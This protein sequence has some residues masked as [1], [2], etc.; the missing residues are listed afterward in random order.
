MEISLCMIVKDEEEVIERCIKSVIEVV[1]EIIIVDTGSV[2]STISIAEK[3]GAKVYN[4]EW[5]NDFSKARNYSFSKATKDYIL[6][7]DADDVLEESSLEEFKKIKNELNENIDS[8][9]MNYIINV[10][11]ENIPI[12]TIRR[13]RLVKKVN[14]FKWKGMVHEYLEVEGKIYI[15]NINIYH[16]K[17]KETT[18]RNLKIYENMIENGEELSARDMYHYGCELYKNN[19]YDESI[20]QFETYIDSKDEWI[21]AI[22]KTLNNLIEIYIAKGDIEN[23]IKYILKLSDYDIP[24]AEFCCKL[25]Y[26]YLQ[27]QQINESIYWY[28]M[29]LNAKC[30]EY[31]ARLDDYDSK[32]FTPWFYLGVC[33]IIKGD[34]KNAHKCNERAYFYKP[35]DILAKN[36]KILL[37]KIIEE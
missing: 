12:Y 26:S 31:Y 18:D 17:E 34:Y 20:V 16:K 27:K 32:T 14:N 28:N 8:V 22:R 11:E 13:N 19:K 23:Q 3:L 36:N 33:N 35:N 21:D 30:I 15:S 6:W 37:E 25:G 2:D 9:M 5:E 7:L 10:N 29:A 24:R 1:D 4:F